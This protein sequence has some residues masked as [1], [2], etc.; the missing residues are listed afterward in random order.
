MPTTDPL[1]T[2]VV[3]RLGAYSGFAD[4]ESGRTEEQRFVQTPSGRLFTT[5]VEPLGDRRDVGF[6]I[7]H[8]FAFEQF[9]LFPLE[10]L[11]ARRAASAGFPTLYV[12]ARGYG[13]SGG[14]FEDV[15]PRTHV[16]DVLAAADHLVDRASVGRVV[17]VGARFGGA[18]ALMAAG[19]LDAPGVALW[20]P[21]LEPG[22]Y[23]D[24]LLRAYSRARTIKEG[25]GAA[26]PARGKS[27]DALKAALAAGEEVDL[28]GYPVTPA[29]YR[30]AHSIVPI[31]SLPRGQ[32]RVL[33]VTVNPRGRK[34]IAGAAARLEALGAQVRLEEAEG[35]G[36]G[37]FGLGLPVSGH[38]ATHVSLFEDVARRTIAWAE[39]DR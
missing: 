6:V 12:Q 2:D 30:E 18:I 13:D 19:D 34:E 36:R 26:D 14:S 39:E 28:L 8:S 17:P 11:F 38:L 20:H 1:T 31:D 3:T 24:S 27:T 4:A 23:L 21:A 35:P 5:L 29:F 9:E 37:E 10:L 7:C 16:R 25:R 33:L 22:P 32:R 15:S